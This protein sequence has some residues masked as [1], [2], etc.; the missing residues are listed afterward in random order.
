MPL[1]AQQYREQIAQGSHQLVFIDDGASGQANGYP[2]LSFDD[3]MSIPAALRSVTIAIAS[4]QVRKILSTRCQSNGVGIISVRASNVVTLD[5]VVIGEGSI[6]MPFS[7]LTSNIS[8]GKQFHSNYHSYVGHDCRIADYVTF[9]P[10]VS[11]NGSIQIEDGVYVGS[12]AV[13]K[14]GTPEKPMVLGA[15]CVI[16]MGAVVTKSVA[17]GVTVVGNPARPF[18]K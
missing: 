5:Q 8:I 12:G 15:G 11:C 16:G 10:R 2:I 3:F 14:Q 17:P 18:V 1:V 7:C 6:L 4:S 13:I 9:G